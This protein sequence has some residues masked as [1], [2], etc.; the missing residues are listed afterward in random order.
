MFLQISH[1]LARIHILQLGVFLGYRCPDSFWIDS[2][3]W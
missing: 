1:N 2:T 3:G